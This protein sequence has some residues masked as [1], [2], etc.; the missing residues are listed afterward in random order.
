M[1]E[2]EKFWSGKFG[3]EY[4]KRNPGKVPNRINLFSK[5]LLPDMNT[6]LELGAGIGANIDAI[7]VLNPD[8]EITAVELNESA[9]A[10]IKDATVINNSVYECDN[11]GKFD[12]VFTSGFL[13][14]VPPER[15]DDIYDLIHQSSKRYILLIEYYNP[16]P[17][18]IE[19][20]GHKGRLWKRD[21][22]GDMI[23]KYKL[24]L[25]NYGFVYHRGKFPLGDLNWFLLKR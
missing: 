12:L 3:D 14:H 6:I 23:D 5:I 4:T 22:A 11:L 20:R 17:T 7:K 1:N 19:Y 2:V 16:T 10:Q 15:L 8:S 24:K 21:F 18:E 13:I 9:S 25:I